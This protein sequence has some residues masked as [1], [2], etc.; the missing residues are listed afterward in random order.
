MKGAR[1]KNP[2]TCAFEY[3]IWGFRFISAQLPSS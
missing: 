3:I 1:E 2:K